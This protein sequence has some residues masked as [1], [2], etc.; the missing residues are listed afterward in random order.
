MFIY[1]FIVISRESPNSSHKQ[2]P[3]WK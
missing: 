2:A 1:R 3:L